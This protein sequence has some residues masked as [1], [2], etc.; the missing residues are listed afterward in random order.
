MSL[1]LYLLLLQYALAF[2]GFI[3]TSESVL[4]KSYYGRLRVRNREVDSSYSYH[5]Y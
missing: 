2:I 3:L 1:F 5:T 4:T